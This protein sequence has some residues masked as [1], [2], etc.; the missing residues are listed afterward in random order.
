MERRSK[1]EFIK[2]KI[3]KRQYLLRLLHYAMIK[4]YH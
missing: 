1:K 2:K 3:R 4:P